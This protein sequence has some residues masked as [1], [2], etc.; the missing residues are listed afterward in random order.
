MNGSPTN[1]V[2]RDTV[3][4][5]GF[6][7]LE[8]M[9]VIAIVAI[10]A[11]LLSTAVNQTKARAH[12]IF[13]LNGLRQ[14]Q[15]AWILYADD[16]D[17]DLTRNRS[18]PSPNERLLGRRNTPDSWVAGNPR[19]DTD[20]KNIERGTLFHYINSPVVYRCPEDRAKVL[21]KKSLRRTRSYSM[22]AYLNG[23]E[24]GL[25]PR[26][27]QKLA[28]VQAQP[29]AKIFVFAEEDSASPWVGSFTVTPRDDASG[30]P[31]GR[32]SSI[33]GTWHNGGSDLS[34]ADGHVE[35]WRWLG[36]RN[37]GKV[38]LTVTLRPQPSDLLRLQSAI[39][40]L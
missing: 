38:N 10:L 18:I 36:A 22:S 7:L 28:E 29:A 13:C 20:T 5:R 34:F 21:L 40:R 17:D 32:L 39:P 12:Q 3:G 24:A 31:A 27:K 15:S 16:N 8:L 26:V 19:E 9:T 14:L 6:T 30:A 1:K 2:R 37:S 11:A 33:P 25:E 23:D 35:Y 4:E